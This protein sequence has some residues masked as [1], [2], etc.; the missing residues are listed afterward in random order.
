MGPACL[1]PSKRLSAQDSGFRVQGVDFKSLRLRG[2]AWARARVWESLDLP[3]GAI[4]SLKARQLPMNDYRKD[5]ED[6]GASLNGPVTS[7]ASVS[8]IDKMCAS[9]VVG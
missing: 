7:C 2:L 8:G 9:I 1:N 3:R 6:Y 4:A 5:I